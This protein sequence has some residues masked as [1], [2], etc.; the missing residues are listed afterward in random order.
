MVNGHPGR[1]GRKDLCG[2]SIFRRSRRRELEEMVHNMLAVYHTKLE[3]VEWMAP[4]DEG[5]GDTQAGEA[6]DRGLVT[7]ASGTTIPTLEIKADDLFGNVRRASLF[8]YH[9][10]LSR[11]GK[12]TDRK[13]WTMTPQTVN[14]V[15]LPLDNGLNFP[16]SD[17]RASVL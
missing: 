3:H 7:A 2:C 12:P 14:A 17:L 15:N 9:Y 11:I 1:C 13:E 8:D 4:G 5:R 10:S 6:G 16:G